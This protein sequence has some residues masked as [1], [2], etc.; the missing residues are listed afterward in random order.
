MLKVG[1]YGRYLETETEDG[2]LKRSSIPKNVP[3]ED[4]DLQK[5]IKFL[6]LPRTVGTHPETKKEILASIG[7]YGPYLKHNNKFISLKEDDVTEIGINRAVE[8]INKKI[9]ETKEDV[10]GTHPETKT[11]IIRKKGIKGRSDYISYNKK[12]Y[13]L[14]KEFNEKSISVDDAIKI[15]NEK[16]KVKK[17]RI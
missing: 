10:I 4:I 9:L 2:K 17:K 7:P 16:K 13:P 11:K 12:N 6:T 15:I 3:N 14:P 5:S 8:L 1:R